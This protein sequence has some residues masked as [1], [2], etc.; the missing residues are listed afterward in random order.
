MR[1]LR[2]CSIVAACLLATACSNQSAYGGL[3]AGQRNECVKMPEANEREQCLRDADK[4]YGQY[5]KE[6]SEALK[7]DQ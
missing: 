7:K 4:S 3:Q 2:A 5:E 1:I 6:R